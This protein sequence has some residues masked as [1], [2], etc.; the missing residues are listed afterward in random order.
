MRY[1]HPGPV[2]APSR[3]STEIQELYVAVQTAIEALL[4][5]EPQPPKKSRTRDP[6]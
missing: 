6:R 2:L 5:D 3:Q 1:V 4:P